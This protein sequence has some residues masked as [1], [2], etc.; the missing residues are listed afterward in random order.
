[1]NTLL[2]RAMEAKVG[3]DEPSLPFA[4]LGPNH[5]TL[6][7]PD[8]GRPAILFHRS[9]LRPHAVILSKTIK[10]AG[11][12][13]DL[14]EEPANA[15]T[16]DGNL[17]AKSPACELDQTRPDEPAVNIEGRVDVKKKNFVES[18]CQ[19]E[20]QLPPKENFVPVPLARR[21][22]VMQ[23]ENS[24]RVEGDQGCPSVQESA[25]EDMESLR[26]D[27]Q[28]HVEAPSDVNALDDDDNAKATAS[29]PASPLLK[30]SETDGADSGERLVVEEEVA[31]ST[32]VEE[33]LVSPSCSA[34]ESNAAVSDSKEESIL[35]DLDN[36]DVVMG[37]LQEDIVQS[38]NIEEVLK[39]PTNNDVLADLIAELNNGLCDENKNSKEVENVGDCSPSVPLLAGGS[40]GGVGNDQLLQ[41]GPQQSTGMPQHLTVERSLANQ[42]FGNVKEGLGSSTISNSTSTPQS[43]I[44]R[45]NGIRVPF[46]FP[47]RGVATDRIAISPMA[48]LPLTAFKPMLR[49]N[50]ARPQ[51]SLPSTVAN[52]T[53]QHLQLPVSRPLPLMNHKLTPGTNTGA[54]PAQPTL[55]SMTPKP[56]FL[57]GG[58]NSWNVGN[59]KGPHVDSL[60]RN[61][62]GS[63]DTNS[64]TITI[65][66][67]EEDSQIPGSLQEVLVEVFR[68]VSSNKAASHFRWSGNG[69]APPY[70]RQTSAP[71]DLSMMEVKVKE[72]IYSAA[73]QFR[74]DLQAVVTACKDGLDVEHPTR[75]AALYLM[76]LAE[77]RLSM[78]GLGR[79]RSGVGKSNGGG[80]GRGR[81][82]GSR[83]GLSTS[84]I[85]SHSL[86]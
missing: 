41:S 40:C 30:A 66:S 14:N 21:D 67:D 19:T 53:H 34:E 32:L 24:S 2:K 47:F 86:K 74:A 3:N 65:S 11:A 50:N 73:T 60:D 8:S 45:P 63:G 59:F 18:S 7:F 51:V 20:W 17:G 56:V 1:L 69:L 15:T 83:E 79:G 46:P 16:V 81:G 44:A 31:D 37:I 76:A 62:Q 78:Y 26:K 84:R 54:L 61:L 82:R 27:F 70:F 42:T 10:D 39:Q 48:C 36:A 22:T 49:D 6:Y 57:P 85:V 38:N 64:N 72:A 71:I 23:L 35:P 12:S 77:Q 33:K 52:Y 75:K 9:L 80:R 58:F 28:D 55:P 43:L 4:Y 13:L 5:P 68:V 29:G 25:Q